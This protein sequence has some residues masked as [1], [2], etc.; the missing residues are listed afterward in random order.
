MSDYLIPKAKVPKP[1]PEKT[2]VLVASGDLRLSANNVCWP[3][4][5]ELEEQARA[6]LADLGWTLVRGHPET[7]SEAEPHGFIRS[8]N[9]GREVF[10]EIDP[11]APLVVAEAVWQYS[12]HVMI[13]L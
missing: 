7:L 1:V 12:H 13:G 5:K 8:Q 3:A 9:H 6:A 4:Q 10:S 11:H 2:A